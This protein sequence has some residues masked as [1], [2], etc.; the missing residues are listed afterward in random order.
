MAFAWVAL[1]YTPPTTEPLDFERLTATLRE[2]T[3]SDT[4]GYWAFFAKAGSHVLVEKHVRI[5]SYAWRRQ[6]IDGRHLD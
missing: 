6:L 2:K 5:M 3:G 4:F 1:S